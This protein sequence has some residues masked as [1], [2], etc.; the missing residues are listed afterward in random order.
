MNSSTNISLKISD[1]MQFNF[2]AAFSILS[3]LVQQGITSNQ[4]N[5]L[6]ILKLGK[7]HE[8][9]WGTDRDATKA[10]LLYKQ[11]A[12]IHDDPLGNFE[13][14]MC[15]LKGIGTEIDI[16]LAM[17]H[18]QAA[19]NKGHAMAAYQIGKLYLYGSKAIRLA[20]NME[21]ESPNVHKMLELFDKYDDDDRKDTTSADMNHKNETGLHSLS[22]ILI[23][24]HDDGQDVGN[25]S[26]L[27]HDAPTSIFDDALYQIRRTNVSSISA[28]QLQDDVVV[29]SDSQALSWF[30]KS[31]DL[32]LALGMYTMALAYETGRIGLQKNDQSAIEMFT[33]AQVTQKGISYCN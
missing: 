33:K 13:L 8:M 22:D 28:S 5:A 9:G 32:Y 16:A 18:L 24:P 4:P 2:H 26:D 25:L 7:C 12:A 29:Q 31:S 11:S 27:L 21:T 3:D 17:K 6:H 20:S 14:G 19:A 15:Y 1:E 30:Q 10:M 23:H